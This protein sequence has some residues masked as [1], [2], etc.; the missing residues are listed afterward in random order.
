MQNAQTHSVPCSHVPLS[1]VPPK[2]FEP[3][4]TKACA[5]CKERKPREE[6][7][8]HMGA[9]D[10][11]RRNCRECLLTGRFSPNFEGKAARK[12][13]KA[14]ESQ[15]R[16][17]QVHRKALKKAAARYPEK[18]AAM[19][20][21]REAVKAGKLV[22]ATKCSAK[23]CRSGKHIEAH[24]WSYSP[25]YHLDVVFLCATHHRRGHSVGF[26]ELKRGFP[27][28]YGIIPEDR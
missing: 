22:R 10:G 2:A 1:F 13:R 17:Q 20:A 25:E 11:L 3:V 6:F 14:R 27:A 5:T 21:V 7:R 23:G 4:A 19:R 28:H 8:R 16:W 24:H 15:E 26:I 9:K 12:R 18:Q